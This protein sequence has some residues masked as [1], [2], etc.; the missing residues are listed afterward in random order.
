MEIP[1]KNI[2]FMVDRGEAPA[3]KDAGE[4]IRRGLRNPMGSPPFLEMVK[5]KDRVLILGDDVTRPTPQDLIIPVL[6]NELNAAMHKSF[7]F[8]FYRMRIMPKSAQ[9]LGSIVASGNP[10]MVM[11]KFRQL[12][13]FSSPPSEFLFPPHP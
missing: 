5:P 8:S 9:M 7:Y 11:L 6:L 3:L 13:I 4:E 1:N 10:F 12:L 2:Y